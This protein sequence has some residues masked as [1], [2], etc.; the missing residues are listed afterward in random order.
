MEVGDLAIEAIYIGEKSSTFQQRKWA[1]AVSGD[2]T[3]FGLIFRPVEDEVSRHSMFVERII[4]TGDFP[5]L[6]KWI[7]ATI[8]ATVTVLTE[9]FEVPIAPPAVDTAEGEISADEL[10][11]I[12]EMFDEKL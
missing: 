7:A 11:E 10:A 6:K 1:K 4:S 3:E 8:A 5:R 9:R 12:E 2:R